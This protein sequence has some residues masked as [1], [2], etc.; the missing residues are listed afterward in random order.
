MK[1]TSFL[2]PAIASSAF[3]LAACSDSNPSGPQGGAGF[4]TVQNIV[5]TDCASCHGALSGRFFLVT[6]DSAAIQQSGLVNPANPEQSLLLLKPTNQTAHGGGLVAE[7][8]TADQSSVREWISRLE[9][10][11][12]SIVEAIKVGTGTSISAPTIDGFYDPAWDRAP[13]VRLRVADGW[14]DAEYVTVQAAYDATYL[15]MVVVWD[16][17]KASNRRQPWVKQADGTWKTLPA[18]TPAPAAGQSWTEYMGTSFNEEDNTRFNYED[19]FAIIWNTYGPSTVAGFDKDG[20]AVACHDPTKNNAPGT[21]Y[22]YGS[23]QSAAKM[24]TSA[25]AEIA[26]MWHWKLVRNNQHYKADDQNVKYWVPGPT[27]A[28]DGGRGG[29]AGPSGYGDNP[30]LSGRPTYRGPSMSGPP[31][32]ILDNQKVAL[33]TAEL[34]GLAAG[35][36]IPNMI[37]SGPTGFRGDVDARGLHNVGMWGLELRRKLV[38]GDP[39]DVQFD[40]LL[41]Q[42]AFGMAIFD[43]AQIEHRYTPMVA[44]LVFK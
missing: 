37:S 33:T 35:S 11:K 4:S 10:P 8:T 44:K 42:Y 29:D 43:N 12:P 27:G 2:L 31:Y 23:P 16:D 1:K 17:D 3:L 9:P 36:E 20:C 15:Y 5:T 26:D 40:S 39:Q 13:R 34:N 7:F 18:K 28:A 14:G 21:T 32:Y 41:R 19:K 25:P 22:N 6:M 38:T 24:Y 30:A